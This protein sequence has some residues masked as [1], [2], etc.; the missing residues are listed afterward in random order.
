MRDNEHALST[1][2]PV[3]RLLCAGALVTALAAA[4]CGGGSSSSSTTTTSAATKAASTDTSTNQAQ[5]YP[6]H[7]SD[8][9]PQAL[10]VTS[11]A[12]IA[13]Q[14]LPARY[15]TCNGSGGWPT[16]KIGNATYGKATKEYV[17]MALGISSG[18]PVRW[19][20]A[21]IKPSVK[22][23]PAGKLPTGAIVGRNSF[24]NTAYDLCPRKAS[25]GGVAF[26]VYALRDRLP[27]EPGFDAHALRPRI[28]KASVATG[29]LFAP[30]S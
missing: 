4:G 28:L 7:P 30:S 29:L 21:G 12:F 5:V 22:R 2:R 3:R 8:Y 16:L 24:G 9:V 11:P 14:P 23:I 17:V 26:Q 19:A 25:G 13:S 27:L 20:V 6:I 1:A 10:A 18:S 15:H